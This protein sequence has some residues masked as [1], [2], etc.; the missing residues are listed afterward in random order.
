MS[1]IYSL[2]TVG[3]LTY[4]IQCTSVNSEVHV[5]IQQVE[6]NRHW[7]LA[8]L[9]NYSYDKMLVVKT[10]QHRDSLNIDNTF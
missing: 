5:R 6:G 2:Y 4:N 7:S 8:V 1:E 10:G 3:A 9:C